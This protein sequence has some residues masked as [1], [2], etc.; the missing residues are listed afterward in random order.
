MQR[1][2]CEEGGAQNGLLVLP[3]RLVARGHTFRS[4]GVTSMSVSQM[5]A[6]LPGRTDMVRAATKRRIVA[7]RLPIPPP[8]A[9]AR[10]GGPTR[11]IEGR[12]CHSPR[13]THREDQPSPAR[14]H[15][16]GRGLRR[17]P[18]PSRHRPPARARCRRRVRGRTRQGL[19]QSRRRHLRQTVGTP[20][21]PYRFGDV[22]VYHSPSP[23]RPPR[24]S[25][26]PSSSAPRPNSASA[27]TS[28]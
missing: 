6:A 15:G 18:R 5:G 11:Y 20:A 3:L 26:L 19:G 8:Q 21:M 2:G 22:I 17:F 12:H 23:T 1:R 16:G 28:S 10:P 27:P 14:T 4:A 9:A 24:R 7:D 13:S 25:T